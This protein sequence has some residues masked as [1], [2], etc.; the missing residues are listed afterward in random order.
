MN[1]KIKKVEK[2]NI[3]E[4]ASLAYAIWHEYW[5]CILSPEQ[6]DYMVENFQSEHAINSK[7]KTKITHIIL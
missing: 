1:F 4:L 5:T 3:K 7:L 2:Q 6:I